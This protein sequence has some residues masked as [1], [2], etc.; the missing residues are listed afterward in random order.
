MLKESDDAE[1]HTKRVFE[2]HLLPLVDYIERKFRFPLTKP[3]NWVRLLSVGLSPISAVHKVFPTEATLSKLQESVVKEH[4]QLRNHNLR[5]Y[6]QEG[7]DWVE[8]NAT[9]WTEQNTEKTPYGY[10]VELFYVQELTPSLQ[11]VKTAWTVHPSEATS[12]RL[13]AS[14]MTERPELMNCVV[15]RYQQEAARW[16][17]LKATDPVQPSSQENPYGYVRLSI[18][19]RELSASQCLIGRTKHFGATVSDVS[20]LASAIIDKLHDVSSALIYEK[21][22]DG[23]WKQLPES[24][25]FLHPTPKNKPYG[26]VVEGL[27]SRLSAEAKR[28]V[29]WPN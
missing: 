23:S 10:V 20:E 5:F 26:Y 15:Y 19:V 12:A 25:D 18:W 13:K 11:L 28:T 1:I 16:V 9:D 14:I 3:E 6:R 21:Q 7:A 8:L 17:E 29:G 22:A 24:Q 27:W 2:Q 4:A